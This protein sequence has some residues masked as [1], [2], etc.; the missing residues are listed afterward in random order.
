MP[1]YILFS[2]PKA[3]VSREVLEA[4]LSY[5]LGRDAKIVDSHKG[6]RYVIEA[7]QHPP[8]SMLPS[9]RD[10][11]LKWR[12]S[13]DYRRQLRYLD[14]RIHQERKRACRGNTEPRQQLTRYESYGSTTA[15]GSTYCTPP[16]AVPQRP[17]MS[18]RNSSTS[19]SVMDSVQG[20]PVSTF[21][22]PAWQ[23]SHSYSYATQYSTQSRR[24]SDAM[25]PLDSGMRSRAMS[26]SSDTSEFGINGGYG[27]ALDEEPRPS[28]S[29]SGRR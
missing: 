17:T 4:D 23:S 21:G 27:W 28:I 13:D 5:Y 14:S 15:N 11:T 1:Q 16:I 8:R 24:P 6:D 10:D 3:D 29:M 9:L 22:S 2:L 18:K 12:G 7:S 20:S 19:G 25:G 26:V